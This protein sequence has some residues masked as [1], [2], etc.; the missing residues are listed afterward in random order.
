VKYSRLL[1]LFLYAIISFHSN[2]QS[3][4][5]K[6]RVYNQIN[7][8]PIA[9][10]TVSIDSIINSIS[11]E[12]G[13]YIIK[14]LTPGTYNVSCSFL[15]FEKVYITELTVTSTK[16]TI[17]DI[18]LIEALFGL[19]VV[20]VTTTSFKKAIESPLSLRVINAS[21]IYRSPGGNR[22]ISK[23]L[24][25]IPGVA[26]TLSFRN[27]IIVRGGAPNENRFYMDGIEIPNIN[28]FATQGSSGGPV[29][30]INVNFLREV[31]FYSGAFPANRGNALSS[32]IDI[33]QLN[34]ND[35]KISGTLMLGSSD[36][37]LTLE[38]PLGKNSVFMLSARRSYLQVLFKALNLPFLPTYTD[39]QYKHL[40][41]LDEKNQL[42]IIGLG[43]IDDFK[44][45]TSVNEKLTDEETIKR[46]DYIL[47]VL[48]VNTQN[49]YVVGVKWSH[50]SEHSFQTFVMSRNHLNNKAFKYKNNMSQPE[51][52]LFDYDSSESENKFRFES[53]KRKNGWKFNVGLGLESVL[54]ENA[55]FNL[56]EINGT[57]SEVN[58]N[59]ELSFVKFAVFSQL[60]HSFYDDKLQ[61]SLGARSDFNNYSNDMNSPLKQFSPRF[62]LSYKI[63]PKVNANFN[64]GRFFQLPPY[65]VMGYRNNAL[66]LINKQNDITY[67]QSNHIVAGLEYNF[68]SFAKLSME[69]FHKA[70][71]KYP[72]LIN[73]QISLANLGGD[74]GVIGNEE[75]TSTSKGRSYG[76]EFFLQQ[77]LSNTV[78]GMLSYTWVR[79]EFKNQ[80]GDYIPSSW[81]NKHILNLTAGKRLKKNW[82]MG[83]KFRL[84]GGAPYTPYDIELSS[85]R[86]I[87]D[88]TQTGIN[89]WSKLNTERNPVSHALDIR[90][91]KKW[92]YKKLALNL[93]LD[94]QN[95][96]NTKTKTQ[97]YV[98]VIRDEFNNPV[99]NPENGQYYLIDEI[100]NTSGTIL[101]SIGIMLEF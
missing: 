65:T 68:S 10:A 30:M 96:Y 53:T 19:D 34:G 12:N 25:V 95:V 56:K 46:N 74:F 20:E 4:S 69:A 31:D 70:Y 85:R 23:V 39:F 2:A 37:G 22:D 66:E 14:D 61:L 59:S 13:D 17:L 6:G 86:D 43:A 98:D 41:N 3:G 99:Q 88:V 48:P 15:G 8:E 100:E 57:V 92:F 24:Q 89:D 97:P 75:V 62:S 42:T 83:L 72:F 54:Y 55:T 82:E 91:D 101:P 36:M 90:I 79:S 60:S 35:E 28:H 67:I 49:N 27:D 29:G 11:D 64:I 52:L 58:F 38:G 32:V 18:P 7:N 44:L 9:F 71:D 50:F 51:F 26:S 5:I 63:A 77:K 80:S 84:L 33:E 47:G 1:A 16:P 76:M 73:D 45:N 81:D 87:W 40:I 78:Y 93:Y 94:I 21:E